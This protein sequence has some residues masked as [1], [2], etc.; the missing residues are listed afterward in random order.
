MT[1]YNLTEYRK[2][3]VV[4]KDLEKALTILKA[5]QIS[6]KTYSKYVPVKHILTT[7]SQE[8]EFLKLHLERY[9]II[10]ETKGEKGI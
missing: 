7:I 3:Q 2:A 4:V 1:I 9:K 6:L 8:K 10:L 5:T